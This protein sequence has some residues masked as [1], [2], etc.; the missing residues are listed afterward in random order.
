MV[1]RAWRHMGVILRESL[2]EPG[3]DTVVA[4]FIDI[5]WDKKGPASS[6]YLSAKL[7]SGHC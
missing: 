6:I 1:R 2:D 7:L 3:Y 5:L 4:R